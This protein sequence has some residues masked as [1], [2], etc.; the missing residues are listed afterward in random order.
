MK[1]ICDARCATIATEHAKG[2]LCPPVWNS[3]SHIEQ[4]EWLA[5]EHGWQVMSILHRAVAAA[6]TLFGAALVA[7][8]CWLPPGPEGRWLQCD[9]TLESNVSFAHEVGSIRVIGEQPC[10]TDD[11]DLCPVYAH[12]SLVLTADAGPCT[13]VPAIGIGEVVLVRTTVFDASGNPDGCLG[14]APAAR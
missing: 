8:F 13:S 4:A 3:L 2:L 7:I 11:A 10:S 14:A 5:Q 6:R 9:G 1:H 12:D